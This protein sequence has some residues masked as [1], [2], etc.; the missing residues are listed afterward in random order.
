MPAW[1]PVALVGEVRQGLW[2]LETAFLGE[3][4]GEE[5]KCWVA[6]LSVLR[7]GTATAGLVAECQWLG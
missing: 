6:Q 2:I 5:E 4:E 1:L 7:S 3:G